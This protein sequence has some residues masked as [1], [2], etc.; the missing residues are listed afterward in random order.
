MSARLGACVLLF[1]LAAPAA[2]GAD[3][4]WR[5]PNVLSGD[6][7]TPL[8]GEIEALAWLAGEWAGDGLGGTAEFIMARPSIG[9]MAGVFKHARDGEVVFYEIIVIGEFEGRTAV[10]IKHFNADMSGWEA[11]DA[12]MEFPLLEV[13]PG[14]AAYFDGLTWRM[15]SEGGLDAFV[16]AR[17]RSGGPERE[18]EFQYRRR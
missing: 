2:Q 12:W 15:N 10:R 16:V 18:F 5:T 7:R 8:S 3:G 17:D 6:G 9:T 13:V 11:Q 4:P 1:A 14:R